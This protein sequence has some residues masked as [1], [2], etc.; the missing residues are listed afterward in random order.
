MQDSEIVFHPTH[1]GNDYGEM[2]R[3]DNFKR[4]CRKRKGVWSCKKTVKPGDLYIFWFGEE[5]Q[6]IVAVGISKG[7]DVFDETK[8]RHCTFD[9]LIACVTPVSKAHFKAD[10]TLRE[11]WESRPYARGAN[12]ITPDNAAIGLVSL[13]R[14][15]DPQ[16][17][18]LLSE[19]IGSAGKVESINIPDDDESPPAKVKCEISRVVR[20]TEKGKSLKNL[21]DHQCQLCGYHIVV[22]NPSARGYVEVH[23]MTP[24]GRAHEGLDNWNNMLVLCPNC[25]VE[26]DIL[27]IAIDPKT[28]R[29]ACCDK[30]NAKT[31]KKIRYRTGHSLSD[32][33]VEYHH[34]RFRKANR[35]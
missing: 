25:H 33:N 23:H 31:G 30:N 28:G 29:I 18:K 11:W 26:F 15:L 13:I 35:A 6:E 34:Q 7:D 20:C 22:P 27:A 2:V 3:Y 24:L 4:F 12:R 21:Y 32:E 16:L 17:D 8:W 9:P 5:K 19:Y 1:C 14:Q 10:P